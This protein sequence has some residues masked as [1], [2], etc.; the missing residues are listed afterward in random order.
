MTEFP[1]VIRDDLPSIA[2]ALGDRVSALS[3]RRV[4]VT[5]ATGMLPAYLVD[6]LAYLN[7]SG[8]LAEPCRLSL[9]C[10][11][12]ERARRRFAHLVHRAGVEIV[13]WDAKRAIGPELSAD[14]IVH[15]AAPAS[16]KDYLADPVASLDVNTL[17][18]RALLELARRGAT[19]VLYISTSE[20]YG[21]PD[22]EAIPTPETYVGRIDPLSRR[23]YYAEAKRAGETYCRAYFEQYGVPVKIARP[24]HVHG[25]GLRRDDGRVVAAL[26]GMGLSGQPLVLESDGRATRTYGYIS[27][28]TVA[29]L[30]LLL[31]RHDGEAFNVGTDRPETSVL[32]LATEIA[33]LFGQTEPVRT[34]AAPASPNASGAPQRACPDLGKLK[35][36]L[37]FSPRVGLADGLSRTVAWLRAQAE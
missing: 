28:A 20:V 7:A 23:A 21:T 33:R 29:M 19:S 25:P 2:D 36:A 3:G 30:G 37:G 9:L 8:L 22:P 31:S 14:Y 35:K 26:I 18:L 34:H 27:D 11:S 10:R 17:A 5:G 4:L 32:E 24:F 1:P 13:I 16:P 15:G 12:A 6:T